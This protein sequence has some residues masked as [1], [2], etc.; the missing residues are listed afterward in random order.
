MRTLSGNTNTNDGGGGG[1]GG[2]GKQ[3]TLTTFKRVAQTSSTTTMSGGTVVSVKQE[4]AVDS[5]VP[6]YV[7]STTYVNSP[8]VQQTNT[9]NRQQNIAESI[10]LQQRSAGDECETVTLP[11][12]LVEAQVL[13]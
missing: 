1:G 13:V 8:Q 5:L 3:S 6:S 11:S 9:V 10:G 12:K 2:G 7:D 4:L